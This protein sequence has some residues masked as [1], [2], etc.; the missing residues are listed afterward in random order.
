MYEY[1]F[2][3]GSENNIDTKGFCNNF[4]EI[5]QETLQ[6]TADCIHHRSTYPNGFVIEMIE[7]ADKIIVKTNRELKDNGNG[8]FTVLEK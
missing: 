4:S 5:L 1:T 3:A 7:Y 6:H 8:N 2:T